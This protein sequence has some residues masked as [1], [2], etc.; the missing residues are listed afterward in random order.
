M[1]HR[2][3]P[4]HELERTPTT[5]VS[6]Q[7]L[8]TARAKSRLTPSTAAPSNPCCFEHTQEQNAL[9]PG[10]PRGAARK[11]KNRDFHFGTIRLGAFDTAV[12]A[13]VTLLLT[14]VGGKGRFGRL[15]F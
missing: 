4:H 7:Y 8:G 2:C 3:I 1:R 11:V 14:D 15:N 5:L 10:I 6:R 13:N 12:V 9:S